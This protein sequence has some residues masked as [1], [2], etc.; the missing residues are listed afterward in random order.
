VALWVAMLLPKALIGY[1][2]LPI[3]HN[4]GANIR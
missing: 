2:L 1:Q 3:H 4:L